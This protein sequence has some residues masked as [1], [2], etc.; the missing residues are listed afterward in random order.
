MGRIADAIAG[1]RGKLVD[2]N[3]PVAMQ[4]LTSQVPQTVRPSDLE[5]MDD[6]ARAALTTP[7]GPFP[8]SVPF[9]PGVPMRP[10]AIN[11]PGAGGIA[12]PRRFEYEI[13]WNLPTPPGTHKLVDFKTL[14]TLADVEP[15]LRRCIEVRK[16]EIAQLD[17]KITPKDP[18]DRNDYSEAIA[19]VTRFFEQPD[20]INGVEFEEWVKMALEEVLVVDALSVYRHPDR[21]GRLHSLTILD[22]TTIKPLLD[23]WGEPATAAI[24]GLPAVRVR[25]APPGSPRRGPAPELGPHGPGPAAPGRRGRAAAG[26]PAGLRAAVPAVQPAIVDAVRLP[27]RRADHPHREPR[28]AP[29]GLAHCGLHGRERPGDVRV[30]AHELLARADRRPADLLGQHLLRPEF[31][32]ADQVGP[33]DAR[34]QEIRDATKVHMLDF[35]EFLVKVICVGTDVQPQEIGFAQDVNRAQ[36][37]MQENVTY[38]RSMRP[39][40]KWVQGLCNGVIARDFDMPQLC[41][42]YLGIEWEDQRQQADIHSRQIAGGFRVIDDVRVNDLGMEPYPDNLGAEPI[43]VTGRTVIRLRDV[44]S[45]ASLATTGQG[46]LPSP[47]TLAPQ[48]SRADPRRPRR[49]QR[50]APPRGPPSSRSRCPTSARRWTASSGS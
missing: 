17:W 35:D 44:V 45:G 42:R 5:Q 43:I 38:R 27:E 15:I 11:A 2:P 37:Q 26:R 21:A 29:A 12:A 34:F 49:P 13:G 10:N 18:R 40:I 31:P 36:G 14:R 30:R 6:A 19:A 46:A 23:Q 22:G 28:P 39:L 4:D 8:L 50:R 16:Q 32:P 24:P 20:R 3:R 1:F 25:D 33:G 9:P 41:L 7:A 47:E 48:R